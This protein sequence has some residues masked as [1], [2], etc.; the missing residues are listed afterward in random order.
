MDYEKRERFSETNMDL[1]G[2]MEHDRWLAEKHSMGWEYG[3]AYLDKPEPKQLR[4]QART[5]CLMIDDYNELRKEAQ[6]KDT[7][8]MNWMLRLIEEYDGLRIYRV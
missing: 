8:P 7:E 3:T 5:H 4:E 6:D 2:P 1:I